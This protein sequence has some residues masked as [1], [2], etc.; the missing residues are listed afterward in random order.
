MSNGALCATSTASAPANSRNAGSAVPS[1][2]APATIVSLM[3]VST[4][5]NGGIG[6]PGVDQRLELAQ[7]LA[8]ADLHRADL[9]DLA[10]LRRPAGGLEVDD[11]EGHLVQRRAQLVEGRLRATATGGAGMDLTVGRT[12]D[13]TAE[14]HRAVAGC[15]V[16]QRPARSTRP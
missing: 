10:A 9:G 8:A 16:G 7:P 11:D 13:T 14:A 2:G 15:A 5:M 6:T 12:V 4:E 1:R 3:P